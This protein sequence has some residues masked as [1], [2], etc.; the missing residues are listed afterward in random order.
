MENKYCPVCNDDGYYG[1]ISCIECGYRKNKIIIIKKEDRAKELQEKK[2]CSDK[3]AR[4]ISDLK[5]NP[6]SKAWPMNRIT[7]IAE[8]CVNMKLDDVKIW[9][10]T[11]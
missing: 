2:D 10:G 11:K 8:L 4:F 1:A 5:S 7:N 6:V 9:V 3:L